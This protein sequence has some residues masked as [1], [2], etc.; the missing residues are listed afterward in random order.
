MNEVNGC[1]TCCDVCVEKTIC[2]EIMRFG[3]ELQYSIAIKLQVQVNYTQ[4]GIL[5]CIC[6]LQVESEL[7]NWV[8]V[9]SLLI[10]IN[11]LENRFRKK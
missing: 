7:A 3:V 8:W 4:E 11:M 1:L 5:I 2:M 9:L 10:G 6:D